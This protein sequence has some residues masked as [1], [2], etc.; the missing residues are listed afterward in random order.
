MSINNIATGVRNSMCNALVDAIDAGSTNANG[1]IRGYTAAFASMLFECDFANPAFGAAASGV[2][3]ANAIADET[4]APAAGDAAVG[5]VV[6][7]DLATVFEF[8]IGTSGADLILNSVSISLG[9]VVSITSMTVT[10]PAS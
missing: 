10:Q 3:T 4:S 5:R 7:R 9:A 6:D 8:T 2:A 1:K